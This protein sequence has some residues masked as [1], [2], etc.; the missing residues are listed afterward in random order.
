MKA[1]IFLAVIFSTFAAS[2]ATST[3]LTLQRLNYKP[4]KKLVYDIN[5]DTDTCEIQLESPFDVYYRDN[6][7]GEHLAEFS[8]DSQKYFGL[9]L[10]SSVWEKNA[11]ALEFKALDEIK[12]GTKTDAR[13]V[14]SIEKVGETCV[15]TTEY[16]NGLDNLAITNIDIQSK[17]TFGLPLGVE[18]VSLHS[19][20]EQG[21]L[22]TCVLGSCQ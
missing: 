1:I 7:T 19:T 14:V 21:V 22:K 10:N 17:L 18:W 20:T 15:A 2:A 11:V 5:Y 3:V 13:I 6:V 9:K 12:K 8:Q 16:S 4:E